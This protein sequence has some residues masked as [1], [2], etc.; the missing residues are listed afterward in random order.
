MN[1]Y[2][3]LVSEKINPE[4]YLNAVMSNGIKNNYDNWNTIKFSKYPH[5]LEIL[6]PDGVYVKFGAVGYND[7]II[8]KSLAK[9]NKIS[10]EEAKIHKINFHKRMKR[11]DNNKYSRRNL[12]LNLLWF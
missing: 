5:K 6:N 10:M 12:S 2:E 8:Y 4:T 1:F 7:F 3:Q 11:K 9:Q